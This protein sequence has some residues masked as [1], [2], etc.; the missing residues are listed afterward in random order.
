MISFST[1]LLLSNTIVDWRRYNELRLQLDSYISKA[2]NQLNENQHIGT[3]VTELEEQIEKHRVREI[4]LS[5][6][7]K[8]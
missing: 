7:I 4:N 8:F 3:T 2:D 1:F 5:E 6:L